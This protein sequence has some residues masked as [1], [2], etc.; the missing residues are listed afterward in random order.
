MRAV[1]RIARGR[2]ASGKRSVFRIRG[3]EIDLQEVVLYFRRRGV[4]I[5]QVDMSRASSPTP[6]AISCHT[7]APIVGTGAATEIPCSDASRS[8]SQPGSAHPRSQ[9]Q[10]D[11]RLPDED[12]QAPSIERPGNSRGFCQ[13]N[14]TIPSPQ[15]FRPMEFVLF[16]VRDYC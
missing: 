12:H 7:P 6:A 10:V 14:P 1:A 16:L 13:I 2:K 11:D 9:L 8:M 5:W 15:V 4:D 3:R